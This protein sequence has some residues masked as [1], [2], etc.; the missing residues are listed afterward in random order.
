MNLTCLDQPMNESSL[1]K[2][3]YLAIAVAENNQTLKDY[4]ECRQALASGVNTQ[5]VSQSSK[6]K[7]MGD[8]TMNRSINHFFEKIGFESRVRSEQQSEG[9]R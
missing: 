2:C 8:E 5:K 7:G 1:G 4:D 3:L 9:K 6:W